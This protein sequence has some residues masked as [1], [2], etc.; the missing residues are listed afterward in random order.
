MHALLILAKDRNEKV[1]LEKIFKERKK[2]V[3]MA[4]KKSKKLKL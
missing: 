3:R 1:I 2:K 4:I